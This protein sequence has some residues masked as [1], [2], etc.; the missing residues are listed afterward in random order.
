VGSDAPAWE[1]GNDV[2]FTLPRLKLVAHVSLYKTLLSATGKTV[3][4]T[5]V[6][7]GACAK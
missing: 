5:L 2:L 7:L 1:R 6:A 4:L 3:V